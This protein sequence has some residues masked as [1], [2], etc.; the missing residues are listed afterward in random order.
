[1]SGANL[2]YI[3]NMRNTIF[4][5][6]LIVLISCSSD[7]GYSG[8]WQKPNNAELID[9]GKTLASNNISGCGQY[10]IKGKY[11]DYIVACFDGEKWKYYNVLTGTNTVQDPNLVCPDCLTEPDLNKL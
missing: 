4:L 6:V 11:G 7:T 2:H 9:I 3:W 8:D 1:M 10:Y 5:A